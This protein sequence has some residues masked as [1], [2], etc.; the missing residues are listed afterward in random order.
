M[1]EHTKHLIRRPCEHVEYQP[2]ADLPTRTLG[3]VE[4][5]TTMHWHGDAN[6][7]HHHMRDDGEDNA[8]K[9]QQRHRRHNQLQ[10][11]Q[12]EYV[13]TIVNA[14]LRISGAE[15]LR[16]EHQQNLRPIRIK[17]RSEHQTDDQ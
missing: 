5:S 7:T 17:L 2:D 16:I 9:Q 10:T 14:E 6:A 8:C 4:Q 3:D 1:R 13:E 12:H 15:T 11:R